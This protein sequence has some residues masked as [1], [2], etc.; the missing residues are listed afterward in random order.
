LQRVVTD[1]DTDVGSSMKVLL[2]SFLSNLPNCV[3]RE[4]IDKVS[5]RTFITVYGATKRF[6]CVHLVYILVRHFRTAARI[7]ART[8]H[9]DLQHEVPTKGLQEVDMAI[10]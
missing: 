6:S 9:D 2:E 8:R 1:D 4:L 7:C 5:T 10:E 3:S